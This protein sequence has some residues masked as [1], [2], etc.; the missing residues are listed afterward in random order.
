ME[1]CLYESVLVLFISYKG[2]RIHTVLRKF[3]PVTFTLFHILICNGGKMQKKSSNAPPQ[4]VKRA[5]SK[6][7]YIYK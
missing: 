5:A 6:V 7:T 2:T 1:L 4:E 3:D